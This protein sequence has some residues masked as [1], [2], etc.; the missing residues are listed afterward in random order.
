MLSLSECAGF[1]AVNLYLWSLPIGHEALFAT[2]TPL[3]IIHFAG[4][5]YV[6]RMTSSNDDGQ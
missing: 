1:F 4:F 6:L 5:W 2:S 3:A